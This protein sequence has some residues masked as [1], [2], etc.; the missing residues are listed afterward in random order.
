MTKIDPSLYLQNQQ[1][2]R[3]PSPELGKNEFLKI[4]MTQLSNQ[5]PTNPMDDREFISQMAQFSSLEQT[6]NMANSIEQLVQ[7]QLVSPVIEYSHMI[8]KE[9]SYQAFDKDTGEKLDVETSKVVAVS[10]KE[11]WAILE[12]KNG[13]KIYA[14][15]VLQVS[16]PTI[17]E[18]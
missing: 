13:E 3:T 6:T 1:K 11:G 16:E 10:Q 7:S 17:K 9:V 4:L 12:L 18:D 8:G 15:A 14:D 2:T 5:D